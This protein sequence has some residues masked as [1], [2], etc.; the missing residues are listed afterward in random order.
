MFVNDKSAINPL[1]K[2]SI[3]TQG[4]HRIYLRMKSTQGCKNFVWQLIT[5]FIRFH[6]ENLIGI[7]RFGASGGW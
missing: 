5:Y 2:V 3:I 7:R 1:S 6:I 4:G